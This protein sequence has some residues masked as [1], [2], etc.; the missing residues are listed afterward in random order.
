MSTVNNG[1]NQNYANNSDGWQLSGGTTARKLT[2]T[3]ADMTMTGSGSNV[4]TMPA[5]TD[6]LVGRV[7]TD[8]M[9]NKTFDS[10][11]P[12]AF[13]YPG[14]LLSY[15][16]RA[17]PTGWLLCY[18]QN[19]SRSTYASLFSAIVPLVGNPTIS[20]ASP[21]VVT[22]S[23]HGFVTG[24]AIYLTTTG[25][26][27]TGLSANTIYYVIYVSSST[28]K[29]A[30][31]MANAQAGTAINTSGSQSGTHSIYAC[32][33]GLGD[34]S[35]TFGIPDLRGRVAAGADAMGGMA[36]SRLTNN[37]YGTQ[38]TY[39]NTG[40]SGGEQSH[41]QVTNELVSHLHGGMGNGGSFL[42]SGGGTGANLSTGGGSYVEV[43]N[44]ASTGGGSA[45]NVVQPTLVMNYIIK[46]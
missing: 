17:A 46:T 45:M 6:T 22:L 13:F 29:L 44:T 34:G 15:T 25:A 23:A 3:G 33:Y 1:S 16:G 14:M 40:Q 26:L 5:S 9:A 24:D 27:P 30:T 2:V 12:T 11:S 32:P 43:F 18:G 41:T 36:A 37:S 31:T 4:Y 28:F 35:T 42:G 19:V 20:I 7:S 21:G 38:G 10:S 39:G 8:T